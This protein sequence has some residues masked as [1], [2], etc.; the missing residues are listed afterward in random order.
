MPFDESPRPLYL[1]MTKTELRKIYLEERLSL[2]EHEYE[3]MNLGIC[4]NFFSSMDF[5][6][7][8]VIHSFI[9]MEKTKEPDTWL[10]IER[11]QEEYPHIRISLPR[12]NVK[13]IDID[14]IFF[15]THK[16]LKTNPWGIPEPQYGEATETKDIDMVLVP[17][18]IGDRRG[19]RV[20]YGKGF[21]DK[22][23][24]T[25]SKDCISVGL[26]FFEPIQAIGDI[27]NLDIP[28]RYFV[29]PLMV[30]RF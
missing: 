1:N 28:L 21:Y 16:Q 15:E 24:S 9:P 11:I 23:L 12:I 27:N 18:L 5:S 3:R 30:H 20:G 25:C 10:I 8:N 22:F 7:I 19:H 13:T 14:N 17:M 26:C 2:S 4:E 29:T 6:K